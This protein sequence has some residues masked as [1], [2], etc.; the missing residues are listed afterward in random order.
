MFGS[1]T[2]AFAPAKGRVAPYLAVVV[3]CGAGIGYAVYEHYNA[4]SLAQQNQQVTAQLNSTQRQ[5]GA[6]VAKVDAFMA[7]NEAKPASLAPPPAIATNRRGMSASSRSNVPDM[8]FK[9]LQSQVDEQGKAIEGAR[10]DLAITRTELSG[11]IA[12]T[13]DELVVLQKK[14]ER[15]YFEFDLEKSKQF[16]REGPLSVSLRK[17]NVKRAYADL[18][19]IVDD[20][21][22]TQKHVNLYQPVMFYQPDSQ[23]PMEVVINDISKDRIHGYIS[24]PKYRPSELIASSD[25]TAGSAGGQEPGASSTTQPTARQKLTLPR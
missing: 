13:H 15:N 16:K 18:Q 8:R 7:A 19:L 12:R 25:A 21:T 20:R 23:Q 3:I 9:K 2:P 22:V 4:Q 17:A 1:L 10:N 24:V 6:L 5:L 11:S 14:G